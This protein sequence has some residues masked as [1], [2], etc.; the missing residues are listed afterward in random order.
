MARYDLICG[1]QGRPAK[2]LFYGPEGIGKSTLAAQMPEP[3]FIDVDGG[4]ARLPVA[5]LPR[6]TSWSMLV[7]EVRAARNGEVPCST[8]VIDTADAAE[9]LARAHVMAR[10]GW[11]SI[12]TPGYGKGYALV[13]EEFSRLLDLLSECVDRGIN[14]VLL[15]HSVVANI[16]RPDEST[17]NAFAPNL[18]DRKNASNAALA[19]A[20]ADLVLFLDYKVYVETDK[21]GKGRATG[22]RRVVRTRHSVTWDAKSRFEL[23]EELSLE[24][25]EASDAIR[26]L[27]ADRMAGAAPGEAAQE[28]RTAPL[29]PESRPDAPEPVPAP[30]SAQRGAQPPAAASSPAAAPAEGA[31]PAWRR[32]GFPETHAELADLMAANS[33]TEEE[34]RAVVAQRGLG[35]LKTPVSAYRGELVGFIV[36]QWPR[37]F[38]KIAEAR[39]LA[40]ARDIE[41]PFDGTDK[42]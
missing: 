27:F 39:E 19:K 6:P 23:P 5:R 15:S 3:V 41:V 9:A 28:P 1:V 36:S 33:V 24:T 32:Y 4:T 25:G 8:L 35:T 34:M 13:V 26:A 2:A 40:A 38:A 31:A 42:E 37:V 20:W 29:P 16:T 14:C 22:G 18:I 12:E 17:Y 7:D 11:E 10:N 30:L 21:S